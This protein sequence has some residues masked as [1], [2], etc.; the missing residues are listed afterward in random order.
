MTSSLEVPRRTGRD[1][2][3]NPFSHTH[4]A[5]AP[6]GR[7]IQ[8]IPLHEKLWATKPPTSGPLKDATAH[9]AEMYA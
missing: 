4:I 6:I 9:T 1:T 5:A 8:K 7:L 2:R 3:R